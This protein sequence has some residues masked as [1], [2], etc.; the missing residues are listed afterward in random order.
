M[1][2]NFGVQ[3]VRNLAAAFVEFWSI[4]D[5]RGHLVPRKCQ[6]YD[7]NIPLIRKD[8]IKVNRDIDHFRNFVH[9]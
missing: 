1:I 4:I 3:L 5:H 7:L 6:I 9:F 2:R 8:K